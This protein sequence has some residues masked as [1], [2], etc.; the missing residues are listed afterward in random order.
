MAARALAPAGGS[1]RRQPYNA[2]SRCWRSTA[3]GFKYRDDFNSPEG[4]YTMLLKS[5]TEGRP[6]AKVRAFGDKLQLPTLPLTLPVRVQLQA[7]NGE[8]WETTHSIANSN[9]GGRFIA[10]AD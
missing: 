4:I 6:S 3:T 1:C 7:A 8:C 10:P 2:D 5:G 9:D